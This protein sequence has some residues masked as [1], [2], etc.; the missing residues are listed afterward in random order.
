MEGRT[1]FGITVPVLSPPLHNSLQHQTT[2]PHPQWPAAQSQMTPAAVA[3]PSG[4]ATPPSAAPDAATL[5]SAPAS[6]EWEANKHVINNLYMDKNLNLNEVVERMKA[7]GFQ[8][9]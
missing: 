8:A 6:T 4:T 5:R 9:T 7:Y 3:S 1:S 2:P